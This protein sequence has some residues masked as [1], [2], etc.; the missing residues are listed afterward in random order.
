MF[1][2]M[3]GSRSHILVISES[4]SGLRLENQAFGRGVAKTN[5]SRKLGFCGFCCRFSYLL[6]ALGPVFVTFDALETGLK[7]D[8]FQ[9]LSGG[10]RS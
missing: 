1:C 6:M 3:L 8:E 5:L 9:C 7:F 2:C 10:G 4:E